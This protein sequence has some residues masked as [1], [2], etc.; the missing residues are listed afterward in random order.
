MGWLAYGGLSAV[1]TGV[2]PILGK[3]GVSGMD[4][5]LAT[6]L[7]AGI[8]FGALLMIIGAAIVARS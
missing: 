2:V 5:T 4:S 3:I 1:F 8:M 6:P 7:R